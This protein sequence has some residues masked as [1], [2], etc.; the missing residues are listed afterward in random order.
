MET[1]GRI[2]VAAVVV[3]L[4]VIIAAYAVTTMSWGDDNGNGNGNGP[5]PTRELAPIFRLT[6]IDG[7][8]ID[9]QAYRGSVVVMDLF[10]IWCG[11]CADQMEHLNNLRAHYPRS[12]VVILSI[13]IEAQETEQE[14]RDYMNLHHA[15]WFFAK[16]TDNVN[17]RYGT[18]SIPHLVII[19]TEGYKVWEHSGVTDMETLAAQIEPLLI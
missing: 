16:D 6:D 5:P 17:E 12:Q 4:I 14:I 18:G 9:L 8:P 7:V 1:N 10:A 13:D 2:I 15:T 11:P 3:V 19:D